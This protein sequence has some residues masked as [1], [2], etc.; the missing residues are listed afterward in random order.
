MPNNAILILFAIVNVVVTALFA[1]V[2]LRQYMQRHRVYQLYWSIALIMA[3]L[4]TLAY[5]FMV[6]VGPTT[7]AGE[8]LF[9]T[10]YI[11]GAAL[12][13]AW[14]GLGSIAL[15]SS[16]RITRISLAILSLLSVLAIVLIATAGINTG[17]LSNVAGT[18][19]KGVLQPGAWIVII[20]V[21]NTL[22]VV[23]V[24]GVAAYSGWK[25]MRRRSSQS[26]TVSFY[27]RNFLWANVLIVVG[28]LLDALAGS[29]VRIFG[30]EGSFWLIMAVGWTVFFIGV[31]LA[32]RRVMS[33]K[34]AAQDQNSDE[35]KGQ[36]TSV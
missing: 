15:I 16:A 12:T 11:F 30:L 24:V 8:L 19:G 26:S 33:A 22:G 1:G 35:V 10:Y 31:L 14:L 21:L 34:L 6:V 5:V 25:L 17:Q 3:F 2:V 29:N 36:A 9:R 7:A 13:S 23:A 28:D 27:T 18:S 20:A 4:G 32:S